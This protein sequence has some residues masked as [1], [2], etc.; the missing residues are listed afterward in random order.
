VLS[1]HVQGDVAIKE[2]KHYFR[3]SYSSL[4]AL[5]ILSSSS[6]WLLVKIKAVFRLLSCMVSAE[7]FS[8]YSKLSFALYYIPGNWIC[9]SKLCFTI[10]VICLQSAAH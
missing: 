3:R 5:F 10:H 9:N 4:V 1:L 6:E 2:P 8:Q 7:S